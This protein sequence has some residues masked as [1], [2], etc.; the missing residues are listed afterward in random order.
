MSSGVACRCTPASQPSAQSSAQSTTSAPSSY[1]TTPLSGKTASRAPASAASLTAVLP[2]VGLDASCSSIKAISDAQTALGAAQYMHALSTG[3][4]YNNISPRHFKTFTTLPLNPF[5]TSFYEP[6][7]P[8]PPDA[9]AAAEVAHEADDKM[10]LATEA[11]AAAQAAE[12]VR[13]AAVV[14]KKRAAAEVAAGAAARSSR[15]VIV[16]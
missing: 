4:V 7:P 12:T 16:D 10:R 9:D 15:A 5:I 8:L 1:P 11:A 13:L 2:F 6:Q 14:E 3:N